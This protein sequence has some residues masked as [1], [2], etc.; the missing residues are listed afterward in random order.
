MKFK[1]T[2]IITDPCYIIR[3]INKVLPKNLKC[4][5]WEDYMSYKDASKYPDYKPLTWEEF[6]SKYNTEYVSEKYLR[7]LFDNKQYFHSKLYGEESK[8][9]SE[10]YEKYHREYSKYDDWAKCDCGFNMSILGLT[11]YISE[12]TVYG[13]W[14]C[15]T[16]KSKHP[17]EDVDYIADCQQKH[18]KLDNRFKDYK[19]IG[20]FCADSGMVGVFLLDEVLKYNP[21]YNDWIDKHN[22]CVTVIPDFDGD[23]EYY[24]D[25]CDNAHIIGTGNTNFMTL[26]TSL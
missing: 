23:V 11:T 13:D 12:S 25:K 24:V 1:G 4:P 9:F 8:K 18:E 3:D 26:Q 16:Y 20:Q 7:D 22:W 14:G 5:K 10:A 15:G 2:I 19:E 21:D 17:K 6:K